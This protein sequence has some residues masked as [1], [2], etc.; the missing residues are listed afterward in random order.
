MIA[1]QIVYP[2][3]VDVFAPLWAEQLRL[4]QFDYQAAQPRTVRGASC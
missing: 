3:V 4:R 1:E 2:F